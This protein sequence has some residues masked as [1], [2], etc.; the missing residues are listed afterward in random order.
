MRR[1]TLAV[2]ATAAFATTASAAPECGKVVDELSKAISGH[3]T[4]APEARVAAMRMTIRAYDHCMVGDR[5]T[6]DA[7]R[8]MVMTQ[9]RKHLGNPQ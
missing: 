6:A 4:M 7:T 8:D 2:L 3:L 9:I 1:M 5:A